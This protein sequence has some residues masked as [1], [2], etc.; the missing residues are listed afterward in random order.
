MTA[1][2]VCGKTKSNVPTV[3]KQEDQLT[4]SDK[5]QLEQLDKYIKEKMRCF[6][7]VGM[8][9]KTVQDIW[10]KKGK[11]CADFFH[12]PTFEA[13]IKSRYEFGKSYGY[14]LIEC[15]DVIIELKSSPIGD[16]LPDNECQCR[17]LAKIPEGE[18]ADVWS[19]VVKESKRGSPI[20]ASMIKSVARKMGYFNSRITNIKP[21]PPDTI[22]INLEC[23]SDELIK[24]GLGKLKLLRSLCDEA[25]STLEEGDVQ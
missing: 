9:L 13:Y 3:A 24:L 23:G 8:A 6:L 21:P 4:S 1:K 18:V 15:A 25:I 2:L 12:V 11:G 10:H 14:R 22:T 20:T 5:K 17:V 19:A 7:E 16:S